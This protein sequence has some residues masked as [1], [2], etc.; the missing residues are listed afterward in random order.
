MNAV[1]AK[2]RR[3]SG[4]ATSQ[5]TNVAA[6][7]SST[8][9]TKTSATRS[10]RRWIGAF[11]PWARWTSSTILANAVSRPTRS[12]RI[13][14]V[15]V[16]LTVAPMTSSPGPTATGID[17]PVS[18]DA[19]IAEPPSTTTPST[20]IR[21]P[22]RTRR[23]SPTRTSSRATSRSRPSS[24]HP[25][26]RRAERG[27]PADRASRPALGPRLEPP[28]EQDQTDDDGRG[29]EV[30]HRLDA[31]R[32]DRAGP[33]GDDGA[34]GP[35][36]GRAD[37]DK[38]VHVRGAVSCRAPGRAVERAT[39]PELDE[40]CRDQGEPVEI[41]HRDR[42]LGREHQEHDGHGGDDRGRGLDQQRT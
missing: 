9:G 24:T 15:P 13:T 27:K 5:T 7:V 37:R 14:N 31:G 12:A 39:G 25:R 19:S 42:R 22:G 8:I 10:A 34:V 20:G 6:A 4:P 21:S 23:R 17:S 36:R 32:F 38:R 1:R 33:E 35:G 29:V 30:G 41:A 28:P 3:G 16:V 18:I 40:R 2:V 26:D 11:D